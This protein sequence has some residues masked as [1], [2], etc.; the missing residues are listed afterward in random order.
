[1]QPIMAFVHPEGT[2]YRSGTDEICFAEYQNPHK[3]YDKNMILF[4]HRLDLVGGC[5]GAAIINEYGNIIGIQSWPKKVFEAKKT[6]TQITSMTQEMQNINDAMTRVT[7]KFSNA[8]FGRSDIKPLTIPTSSRMKITI[9]IKYINFTLRKQ[10]YNKHVIRPLQ[11]LI[12]QKFLSDAT[13]SSGRGARKKFQNPSSYTTT[14]T[15]TGK[16]SV[17]EK[18]LPNKLLERTYNVFI[19]NLFTKCGVDIFYIKKL[20]SCVMFVQLK[21]LYHYAQNLHWKTLQSNASFIFCI[22]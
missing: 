22:S 10:I 21:L 5:S 4:D 12:E 11:E 16:T 8:S 7:A 15:T 2:S 1:M 20:S 13:S 6:T 17:R 14:T 18:F 19:E 3:A 9:H